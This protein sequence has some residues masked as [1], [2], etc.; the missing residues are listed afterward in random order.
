MKIVTKIAVNPDTGQQY[1]IEM[2]GPEPVRQAILELEYP[3]DG[4][5][6]VVA[7]QRLAEKFQLVDGQKHAKNRSDLNVFRYDVVAPQFRWLLRNGKLVQ[8]E[9]PKTPY[10][11]A[12]I[13]SDSSGTE[14]RENSCEYEGAPAVEMVERTAVRPN[15]GEEYQIKV[16]A[17]HIVKQ[18]LL[19]YEYPASGIQIKDIAEILADQFDLSKEQRKARGKYGLVWQRHVNIAA[20]S[21]VNSG[22][23]LGI[24]RGWFINPDQPDVETSDSDAESPFSDGEP[25]AP[26]AVIAQNYRDH[27]DRLKE[28]LWQKIM[29]NPPEFFEELV[30][31]LI[32]KMGYCGSRADAEAVGRSGDGGIDGI[33]KED[34]LGLD[35]IYVQAKRQQNNV[36]VDTVRDFTGALDSKGARKGIFIT[37]S[38][39]TQPAKEFAKEVTSKRI[40]LINGKQLVELMIDH[41]L[42]V[43]LGKFY[44]LK[45]V[46]IAYFTMDDAGEDDT[47]DDTGEDD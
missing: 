31:D 28:E 34:K 15:T 10:L 36:R 30:L 26:E 40:I 5:R 1:L 29:D 46:D 44:Q 16:P 9:G 45:E 25:S 6:V 12:E 20:N 3:Q 22:K 7:T 38:D 13:N 19:D 23:L 33:I 32:F 27:L 43:S 14:L 24:K 11:L 39:F 8:T 18:A 37:T 21:L 41:N 42:G 17:T 35:L 4:I 2:P 47:V